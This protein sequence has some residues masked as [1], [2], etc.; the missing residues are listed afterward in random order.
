MISLKRS[1]INILKYS[2]NQLNIVI[3]FTIS[4]S[5]RIFFYFL[6]KICEINIYST[7]NVTQILRQMTQNDKI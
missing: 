3:C 7:G 5:N 2:N 6:T 1:E 4:V